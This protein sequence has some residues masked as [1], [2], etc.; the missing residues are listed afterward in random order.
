MAYGRTSCDP[1]SN[2]QTGH[3]KNSVLLLCVLQVS[4]TY[5]TT[6]RGAKYLPLIIGLINQLL[7]IATTTLLLIQF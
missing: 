6:E 3:E 7:N 5:S 2:S 4:L 1:W